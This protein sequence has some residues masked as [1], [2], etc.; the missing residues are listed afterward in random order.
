ME[1]CVKGG[2]EPGSGRWIETVQEA[3]SGKGSPRGEM[4]GLL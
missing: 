3:G 4:C 1:K 2:V